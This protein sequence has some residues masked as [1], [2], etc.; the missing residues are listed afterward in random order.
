MC[1][2]LRM[3]PFSIRYSMCDLGERLRWRVDWARLTCPRYCGPGLY[4]GR[5]RLNRLGISVRGSPIMPAR[6]ADPRCALGGESGGMPSGKTFL[7][8]GT[9]FTHLVR[10]HYNSNAQHC[11]NEYAFSPHYFVLLT[12]T[13]V[14]HSEGESGLLS[15]HFCHHAIAERLLSSLITLLLPLNDKHLANMR[16][17]EGDRTHI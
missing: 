14:L 8:G 17:G 13:V 6:H 16:R 11:I 5:L 3:T 7:A 4:R 10:R 9:T 15:T 2:A 1:I 12:S